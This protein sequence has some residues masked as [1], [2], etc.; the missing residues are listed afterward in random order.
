MRRVEKKM[1]EVVGH[2]YIWDEWSNIWGNKNKLKWF[3]LDLNRLP[4][5]SERNF[6]NYAQV[7]SGSELRFSSTMCEVNGEDIKE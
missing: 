5:V 3:C 1:L 7:M 4:T 6:Q 2:A